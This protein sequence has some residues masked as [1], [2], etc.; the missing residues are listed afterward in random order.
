MWLLAGAAQDR[1]RH[2]TLI[3]GCQENLCLALAGQ[4]A[5]DVE[6]IANPGDDRRCIARQRVFGDPSCARIR[7][8]RPIELR[9]GRDQLD[10]VDRSRHRSCEDQHARLLELGHAARRIGHDVKQISDSWR[11]PVRPPNQRGDVHLDI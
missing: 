11:Q 3:R 7:C 2:R 4:R 10:L 1:E 9:V 6:G 5:G 8:G